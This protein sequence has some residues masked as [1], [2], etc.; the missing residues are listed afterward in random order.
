[1]KLFRPRTVI[2]NTLGPKLCGLDWKY[3]NHRFHPHLHPSTTLAE[4]N[5][6]VDEQIPPPV[7]S[8]LELSEEE[9]Q[10]VDSALKNLVGDGAEAIAA[11]WADDGQLKKKLKIIQAY[12]GHGSYHV[13]HDR[14]PD[15]WS[16]PVAPSPPQRQPVRPTASS[17]GKRRRNESDNSSDE[18]TCDSDADT[19]HEM[20]A[21][22]FF[23][24]KEDKENRLP[25]LL[26]A[27]R[28]EDS[29]SATSDVR[30]PVAAERMMPSSPFGEVVFKG[31]LSTPQ[32]S[33]LV[34]R[35]PHASSS[36]PT[37]AL[38]TSSHA[39]VSANRPSS[40]VV[41][42]FSTAEYPGSKM[43]TSFS[44]PSPRRTNL[45]PSSSPI[46]FSSPFLGPTG[47]VSLDR[48]L[49][50]GPLKPP[51]SSSS[52]RTAADGTSLPRPPSVSLS[53][54]QK[55]D[56]TGSL[57]KELHE[58]ASSDPEAALEDL[59]TPQALKKR[60]IGD[61]DSTS[62][63]ERSASPD[64]TVRQEL[65]ENIDTDFL[66]LPRPFSPPASPGNPVAGQDEAWAQR[67]H[68]RRPCYL[69][70]GEKDVLE[71]HR[72]SPQ[73]TNRQKRFIIHYDVMEGLFRTTGKPEIWGETREQEL[74]VFK[75]DWRKRLTLALARRRSAGEVIPETPPIEA[76]Q[77][78]GTSLHPSGVRDAQI[79]PMTGRSSR[80][81][82]TRTSKSKKS[83]VLEPTLSS[84]ETVYD[85]DEDRADWNRS[86]H[87]MEVYKEEIAA[88]KKP[89][90]PLLSCTHSD[91]QDE[92]EK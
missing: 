39:Q 48:Q 74:A 70:E 73:L 12:V 58:K 71:R 55:R 21:I 72:I 51:N 57:Y 66:P 2:P 63:P 92:S 16:S 60:R 11:R 4:L 50:P 88:G 40:K 87:L 61:L 78:A 3:I 56:S 59:P 18:E 36:T 30:S 28:D 13:I 64:G 69:S 46:P 86:R 41:P 67:H 23:G 1:M 49:P 10:D 91:S 84:F 15:R 33:P 6:E 76:S 32:I 85:G 24:T 37:V 5:K 43:A 38:V 53:P 81:D 34:R 80:W 47:P 17:Y 42:L 79:S 83:L 77:V 7:G 25:G 62:L 19:R 29:C 35:K 44:S 22:A 65:E 31:G 68:H 14:P 27:V 8:R 20:T 75:R 45:Q 26:R 52:K 89:S 82:A 9:E 90:I 54:R